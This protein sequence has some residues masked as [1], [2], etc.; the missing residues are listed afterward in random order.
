MKLP[1]GLEIIGNRAFAECSNLESLVI[2]STVKDFG[3]GIINSDDKLTSVTSRIFNP[4]VVQKTTFLYE[5]RWDEDSQ[6]NVYTP[7]PATLYVH[8]GKKYTYQNTSGWKEFQNIE[9]L[10]VSG[11]A[12]GDGDVDNQDLDIVVRY[13]MG[14]KIENFIFKNAD[15]NEDDKVDVGDVVKLIDK[16]KL[17]VN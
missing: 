1:E 4:F 17:A 5:D 11:D 12:N 6:E 10:V 3:W 15:T 9:E 7:S 14:E 2:P 8:P 13:I 16:L